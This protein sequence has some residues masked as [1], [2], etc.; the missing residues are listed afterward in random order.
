MIDNSTLFL[1]LKAEAEAAWR[2]ITPAP[3][4]KAV[5][6]LR[7]SIL[8]AVFGICIASRY[9]CYCELH[10]NGA[11]A[12]E[13]K[14]FS[15]FRKCFASALTIKV[16][17][18][19]LPEFLKIAYAQF[20]RIQPDPCTWAEQQIKFLIEELRT[21]TREYVIGACDGWLPGEVG[22]HRESWRAPR[23]LRMEPLC[24]PGCTIAYD[25]SEAWE[26]ESPETTDLILKANE[27]AC[28]CHSELTDA[29]GRAHVQ[30]AQ[31]LPG[32]RSRSC[33]PCKARFKL[34]F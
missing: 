11:K 25:S 1:S 27:D 8:G 2:A 4:I 30:F 22:V 26:R 29:I 34:S 9:V 3:L 16:V 15:F 14:C 10:G 19:T 17:E 7:E 33:T 32:D 13:A 18:Q 12:S 6:H 21:D 28:L 20:A 5:E 24:V 31:H 23:F